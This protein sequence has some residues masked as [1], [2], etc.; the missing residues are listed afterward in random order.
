MREKGVMTRSIVGLILVFGLI[1]VI[2]RPVGRL[3]SRQ[4]F[5]HNPDPIGKLD[6]GRTAFSPDGQSVAFIMKSQVLRE[7]AGICTFP[8]GGV[9]IT[10]SQTINIYTVSLAGKIEQ[11]GSIDL[12]NQNLTIGETAAFRWDE[13]GIYFWVQLTGPQTYYYAIDPTTDHIHQLS[14]AEGNALEREYKVLPNTSPVDSNTKV[15][16]EDAGL[17]LYKQETMMKVLVSQ[18][19]FLNIEKQLHMKWPTAQTYYQQFIYQPEAKK[20]TQ[21]KSPKI[22][23]NGYGIGHLVISP[24][25]LGGTIRFDTQVTKPGI[26]KMIATIYKPEYYGGQKLAEKELSATLDPGS[27]SEEISIPFTDIMSGLKKTLTD[28]YSI[29]NYSIDGSMPTDFVVIVSIQDNQNAPEVESGKL[30]LRYYCTKQDV[31]TCRYTGL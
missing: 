8:D 24:S 19:D 25:S 1:F 28:Q 17:T 30:P 18:E 22:S 14:T 21:S 13:K 29:L 6:T 3:A 27:H 12:T 7:P 20:L 16:Q 2:Y 9:P 23:A 5:C 11:K 15:S 10:V 4:S 31:S 26:Y